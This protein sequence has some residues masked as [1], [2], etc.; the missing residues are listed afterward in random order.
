MKALTRREIERRSPHVDGIA[1]TEPRVS[2][3]VE[4]V[5]VP[6]LEKIIAWFERRVN[7]GTRYAFATAAD[8]KQAVSMV[9]VLG[10]IDR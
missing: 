4:Q 10:G 7:F 3:Q 5:T 6:N 2:H 1:D 8:E 9:K